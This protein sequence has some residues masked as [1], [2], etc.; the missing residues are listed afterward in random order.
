MH[1]GTTVSIKFY[2]CKELTWQK[3]GE[4]N[5]FPV[6]LEVSKKKNKDKFENIGIDEKTQVLNLH[7]N[8][9]PQPDPHNFKNT[10]EE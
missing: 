1:K 9:M 3:R 10:I 4:R 5:L 7:Q 2:S 8:N 6:S